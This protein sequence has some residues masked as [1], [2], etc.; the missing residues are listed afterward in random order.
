MDLAGADE[1]AALAHVVPDLEVV[2]ALAAHLERPRPARAAACCGAESRGAARS[3]VWSRRTIAMVGAVAVLVRRREGWPSAGVPMAGARR[4]RSC[5]RDAALVCPLA[6]TAEPAAPAAVAS[7]AASAA[8]S[9]VAPVRT[10]S[11]IVPP[12]LTVPPSRRPRRRAARRRRRGS[13]RRC[14]ARRRAGRRR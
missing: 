3:A 8:I 14:A 12:A 9:T 13:P 11:R 2:E 1:A 7:A 5:A 10:T 4:P 6:V